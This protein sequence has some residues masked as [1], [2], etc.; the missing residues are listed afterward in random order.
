[1]QAG[2]VSGTSY[3]GCKSAILH[4]N[5][6]RVKINATGMAVKAILQQLYIFASSYTSRSS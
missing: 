4:I 3:Q 6:V 5:R 2:Q 1:M